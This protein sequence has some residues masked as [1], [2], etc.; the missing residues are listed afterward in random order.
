MPGTT[1]QGRLRMAEAPN[2][3]TFD[4]S[5]FI[6]PADEQLRRFQDLPD[7]DKPGYLAV[8]SPWQSIEIT[9]TTGSRFNITGFDTSHIVAPGNL[10]VSVVDASGTLIGLSNLKTV[11]P[12]SSLKLYVFYDPAIRSGDTVSEQFP[13]WQGSKIATN[14]RHAFIAGD[15]LTIL[16]DSSATFPVN[17]VGGSTYD[18]DIVY[19]G[20]V[21]RRDFERLND[22]ILD[23]GRNWPVAEALSPF[24]DVT[25]DINNRCP[26]GAEGILGTCGWGLHSFPDREIAL[27]DFG[28]LNAEFNRARAPFLDLDSDNSSGAQGADYA[29]EFMGLPILIADVDAR[30]ANRDI[31]VLQE[32]AIIAPEGD[33]L[34]IDA[35]K[36]PVTI[37]AQRS[38][39]EPNRVLLTGIDPQSG[40]T[41]GDFMKTL[42]AICFAPRAS[43][44]TRIAEIT[45]VAKGL[46]AR[47]GDPAS[48]PITF[49]RL[50]NDAELLG[51]AAVARILVRASN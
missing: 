31:R 27:G 45:F 3:S 46:A 28:T 18:S 2:F 51:N 38:E 32:L 10:F 40:A 14:A 25:S 42:T 24:F 34:I 13:D 20:A 43:T 16:T 26:N 44:T 50:Q 36:L 7:I 6:R 29:A 11:E 15:R 47:E 9:N 33:S 19:D 37:T 22:E 17:L 49:T 4:Y 48:L 30:F 5:P 39:T 23:G 12:D 1:I 41:V 21:D 35:S 8:L